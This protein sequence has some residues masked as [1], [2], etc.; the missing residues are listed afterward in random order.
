MFAEDA[1]CS[2]ATVFH[3]VRPKIRD[4]GLGCLGVDCIRVVWVQV[5]VNWNTVVFFQIVGRVLEFG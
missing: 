2:N 3:S 1:D 4:D 5:S